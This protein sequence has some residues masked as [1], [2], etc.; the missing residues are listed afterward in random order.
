MGGA[1]TPPSHAARYL[2]EKGVFT[3]EEAAFFKKVVGFRNVIVHQYLAVDVDLVKR[4]L[5]SREYRKVL[6]LAE[7]IYKA[8]QDP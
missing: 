3:Q 7:K 6:S 4:V 5:E 8:V 2:A 1:G